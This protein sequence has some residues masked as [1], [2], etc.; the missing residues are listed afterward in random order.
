MVHISI[1]GFIWLVRVASG[2]RIVPDD[3][4]KREHWKCRLFSVN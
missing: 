2:G 4:E 1:N 3:D